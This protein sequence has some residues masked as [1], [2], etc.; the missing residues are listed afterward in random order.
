MKV[1]Q[2]ILKSLETFLIRSLF[3]S[4]AKNANKTKKTRTNFDLITDSLIEKYQ[5]ISIKFKIGF[6][7][8]LPKLYLNNEVDNL[9]GHTQIWHIS[10]DKKVQIF[11]WLSK[12]K[13]LSFMT[14]VN[15][16][17]GRHFSMGHQVW[18]HFSWVTKYFKYFS[19][20][21]NWHLSISLQKWVQPGKLK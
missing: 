4:N 16:K 3:P 6:L 12:S 10:F 21:Y 5:T 19:D 20:F 8:L 18:H 17:S 15:P 13:F 9:K 14:K 7:Y 2:Y 11:Q 1:F